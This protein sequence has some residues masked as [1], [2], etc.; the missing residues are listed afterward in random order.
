LN[1]DD[2]L[3]LFEQAEQA[4]RMGDPS[5]AAELYERILQ[6]LGPKADLCPAE[7]MRRIARCHHQNNDFRAAQEV[8]VAAL[9]AARAL[10]TPTAEALVL[11]TQAAVAQTL[12]DLDSAERLY[13]EARARARAGD[14]PVIVAMVDQN[15]G[16]LAN[17]RGNFEEA[18][19]RYAQALGAY[20][21]LKMRERRT[22]LLANI[23]RLHTDLGAWD[24]AKASFE[25]AMA[26]AQARQDPVTELLVQVNITRMELAREAYGAAA[27][28]VLRSEQLASDQ[29]DNRWSGLI[30]KQKAVVSRESGDLLGAVKGL[31][32]A[33]A[34]A[35]ASGDRLLEAEVARELA[36]THWR[37]RHNRETL[38][39]L[40]R[41]HRLFGELQAS[42]D[43]ADV[44]GRANDLE[45]LFSEIVREWGS[46]IESK[47]AYTHGHSDRV[48]RYALKLADASGLDARDRSWF[49][50]GA[51]LHDVG[52]VVVPDAILNKPGPLTAAEWSVMRSHSAEGES[53]LSDVEFPWDITPM[54]RHH[55]EAWDGSGYPDNLNGEAIP[56]TARV[57][58]VADV[59]DALTTA[60][61]YRGAYDLNDAM[62]IMDE[63]SGSTLDPEL[64]RI[65]RRLVREEEV[66]NEPKE[67]LLRRD[68]SRAAP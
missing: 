17:T 45:E 5:A 59:F 1:Q 62:G 48:A 36:Q 16:T 21:L 6:Q 51:L 19:Q 13:S 12:G 44:S 20:E 18:L 54:V 24:A 31:K 49:E 23:G 39:W 57:L 28:S 47:D 56:W 14:E 3:V 8:L 38:L 37:A 66:V 35:V 42:H 22:P 26:C 53:L 9:E 67:S 64:Y 65:F 61:P 34:V 46:S 25:E 29:T 50:M 27:A 2:G 55:H 60:R 15:L 68:R 32:A 52:K 7:T 58:C 41:A 10:G 63:M 33:R 43:L 4:E 30:A 11:N 40:N